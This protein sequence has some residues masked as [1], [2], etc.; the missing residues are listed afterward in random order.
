MILTR[1]AAPAQSGNRFSG[2]IMLNRKN[3]TEF[4]T[5]QLNRTL[6]AARI[7]PILRRAKR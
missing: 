7:D 4:D 2:K 6:I 1:R 3:K 5:T